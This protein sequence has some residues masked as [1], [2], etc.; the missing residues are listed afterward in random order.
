MAIAGATGFV[1]QSLLRALRGHANVIA[2]GRRDPPPGSETA[3]GLEWRRCDLFSLRDTERALQGADA[4]YYLVH[5]M[6][7]TARLTQARF[8]DLDLLLADNFARAASAAGVGRI[9]YLGGLVPDGARELSPHL[10]SRLEVE[11][12]LGGYGV[13]VTAVRAGLVVGRGGSSLEIL[14]RLVERLPVMLLPRWTRTLSQPI[15]LEDLVAVLVH[16]LEDEETRGRVCEVGGPEVLSYADMMR[17]TAEVLGRRRFMMPVPFFSPG[18]SR[19]W[20]SLITQKPR[21]LV[22]P[23]VQSLRHPMLADDRWI[24]KRMAR[25]GQS[26]AKSLEVA[27]RSG[28]LAKEPT[29]RS[30]QRLPLPAGRDATWIAEEYAAWLPRL[31]G[32]LLVVE[33][34]DARCTFRLRGMER[35]LLE[36]TYRPE[37]SDAERALYDVTGGV[38]ARTD[39]GTPRLEFRVVPGSGVALAAVQ[40]FRPR[41]PWWL[42]SLTQA[43]AHQLVMTA[44]GR[45][46]R[47]V[48]RGAA[49]LVAKSALAIGT[50][51]ASVNSPRPRTPD[52]TTRG[53]AG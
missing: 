17:Q 52:A 8:E 9:V 47:R 39:G 26:Y 51:S 5:S 53:G 25:D 35:E 13:P 32:S 14:V 3:A 27:V 42:Y 20:V 41:L 45:H 29:V 2:L 31:F 12:A 34:D 48:A 23:L 28:G 19:L 21:A 46:L 6:M 4:A 44:F 10:A 37:R 22:A 33:L 24:Q 11:D 40:D 7:P 18:L 49:P 50:G 38:L 15:A 36:L 16:C 30:V 43:R 1:G